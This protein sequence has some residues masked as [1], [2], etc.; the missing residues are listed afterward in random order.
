[1]KQNHVIMSTILAISLTIF[2]GCTSGPQK[3][4]GALPSLQPPMYNLSHGNPNLEKRNQQTARTQS[5]N[6]GTTVA[7]V[8]ENQVV[9]LTNIER[10]KAGLPPLQINSS[11]MNMARTKAL[12]MINQN[13]F[14]HTSPTYGSPFDM[15][16]NWGIGF[17][18]GGENIAGNPIVPDAMTMWMN[19]PGHRANILNSQYSQIGV[20]VVNGGP[21]GK[22]LVQE[23]IHP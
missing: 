15:M 20:G 17:T 8:D 18:T 16:I 6:G 14:D 12:D 9:E 23:F 11:L 2:T 3:V 1:M 19:S 10:Q 21:Y 4:Q 7:T 5:Y 22:M 13:Y